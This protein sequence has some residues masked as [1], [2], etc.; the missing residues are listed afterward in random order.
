VN[1]NES[2]DAIQEPKTHPPIEW[3]LASRWRAPGSWKR[4]RLSEIDSPLTRTPSEPKAPEGFFI[5]ALSRAAFKF[6]PGMAG[7][8]DPDSGIAD[9]CARH[10]SE[11]RGL[12][13]GTRREP[14]TDGRANQDGFAMAARG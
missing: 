6:R 4:S 10:A 3:L 12:P 11:A 14:G 5:S 7:T 8:E 9:A 1:G 13:E 2:C